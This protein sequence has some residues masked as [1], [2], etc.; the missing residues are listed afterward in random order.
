MTFINRETGEVLKTKGSTHLK[1]P[2]LIHSVL[3]AVNTQ[4]MLTSN[5]L[6]IIVERYKFAPLLPYVMTERDKENIAANPDA[7]EDIPRFIVKG[8]DKAVSDSRFDQLI[9]EEFVER[10]NAN[11]EVLCT[12]INK[13]HPVYKATLEDA[14]PIKITTITTQS[15]FLKR[16]LKAG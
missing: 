2:T 16:I 8:Y 14:V 3:P 12:L 9:R 11:D 15:K 4:S 1:R 7:I 10:Y 6:N 13:Y 5:A